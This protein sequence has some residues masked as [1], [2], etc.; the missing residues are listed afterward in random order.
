VFRNVNK[1]DEFAG[2]FNNLNLRYVERLRGFDPNGIFVEHLLAVGFNNS[3]IHTRLNEDRD[4]DD[5]TPA[6][7]AGD[8]ETLQST[9]ELYKQ[10]GKGPGEKSVQ[11][12]ATTPKSTTSQSIAPTTH[13]SKKETQNSSNGGGDKNPPRGKIDSSHKLPVRK[14]RK[15]VVGQAEEPETE[16]EDMELETDLDNVFCNVDQPGDAIHHNP[17]MEIVETDIFDEDESFVFQ[18]V[19]FDN[20]SKNLII[21]KRDVRNKKG[22]SRSEINLRN[23]QPSQISRLHRATRDALDDSIGGIEAENARL[24][25][26]IKELE[27]ALIPIPLLASP[28]AITVPATPATKLKGSS[29]LLT[30]C[31][32]YVEK[33]IKKIMEL[34]TQAWE[35]SKSI[36]S[37]GTRAHALHE[38]LQADLKNEECFYLETVL[39]FGIH[40]TNMTDMRRRQEDLPSPNRIKQLNACWKEKVKNLHLIVQ[41]CEQAIS[42]KEELF[43]KLTEIDLAGS[44]NEVQDPNLILNSLSL[45]KQ[46]FDEQVD[47]FKGLSLEK[48]YDILEYG[49]D[50]VDNW[51]VDY[52]VQN[53]EIDQ[54]LRNLSIDL[55][56]LENEIFNI[57]IWDEINVAP[58]RSYIEEWLQRAIDKLT[59]EGKQAVGTI[60][61]VVDE[62]NKKASTSK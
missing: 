32:G 30:S 12:P 23:M 46:A 60:P 9:T 54:A 26:R 49:E 36:A 43:R 13:P 59:D 7:D 24:K 8:L 25:D 62:S 42:K 37:L 14:K 19:V 34:I 11:S 47:I 31:R 56:E 58:M 29:S 21:E 38:H 48:F 50:D 27:E 57:K 41:S 16:S 52:S 5:N 45:T 3:F 4:N 2:H 17:L 22:K 33:N 1:I 61:V 40:V 55:R 20:E 15:N 28:L 44:T 51:L 18:S 6:P 53:E 35:T 10:Q 39:P